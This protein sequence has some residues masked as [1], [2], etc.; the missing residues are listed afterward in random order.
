MK[1]NKKKIPKIS[2]EQYIAYIAS[3]RSEP[4]LYGTDGEAFIPDE[5]KPDSK[6]E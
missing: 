5:I 2:D 6:T 4:A 3:L 1:K